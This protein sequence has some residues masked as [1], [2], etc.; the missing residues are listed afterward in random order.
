MVILDDGPEMD[1]DFRYFD[2]DI[3]LRSYST[4]CYMR[5]IDFI[6]TIMLHTKDKTI[7]SYKML[8]YLSMY[9]IIML[10]NKRIH[11]NTNM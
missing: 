8:Q 7:S 5:L 10:I 2:L 9:E 6:I 11:E 3:L 4:L 1:N